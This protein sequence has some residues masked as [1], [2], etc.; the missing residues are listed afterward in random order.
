MKKFLAASLA[1]FCS[2]PPQPARQSSPQQTP[3]PASPVTQEPAA[4][5]EAPAQEPAEPIRITPNQQ[6]ERHTVGRRLARRAGH[7]QTDLE[8]IVTCTLHAAAPDT[9]DGRGLRRGQR[10]L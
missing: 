5:P 7:H 8:E 10:S 1:A 3:E 6:G 9:G 4:Q 2:L